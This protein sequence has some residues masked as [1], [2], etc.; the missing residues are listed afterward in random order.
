MWSRLMKSNT[1]IGQEFQSYETD[2][3]GKIEATIQLN[4][5]QTDSYFI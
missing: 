4:E 5:Y 3:T 2:D 1:K